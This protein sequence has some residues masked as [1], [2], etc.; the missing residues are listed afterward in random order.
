MT[1]RGRRGEGS[2]DTNAGYQEIGAIPEPFAGD[3]R[4]GG[5][6]YTE[7]RSSRFTETTPAV[8]GEG[9]I[10]RPDG[11]AQFDSVTATLFS[12][13]SE[14]MRTEF[15]N[16]ITFIPYDYDGT[17]PTA[18]WDP[19]GDQIYP[20]LYTRK[21]ALL[22]YTWTRLTS[23]YDISASSM[24]ETY[25]E[26]WHDQAGTLYSAGQT[27]AY[28]GSW[29]GG[30]N[31]QVG[32]SGDELTLGAADIVGYGVGDPV[33][34]TLQG[35]TDAL[36]FEDMGG[37]DFRI[38]N[39]QQGNAIKFYDGTG[40]VAFEYNSTE[41]FNLI[42]D[43]TTGTVTDIRFDSP[44][45]GAQYQ[46]N[47][48]TGYIW[49]GPVN[50]TYCHM[51]TDRGDFYFNKPLVSDGEEFASY[52]ANLYLRRTNGGT[53]YVLVGD[54]TVQFW[55]DNQE[56]MR[57]SNT[58]DLQIRGDQFYMGTSYGGNDYLQHNEGSHWFRFVEDATAVATFYNSTAYNQIRLHDAQAD[59]IIVWANNPYTNGTGD[60][61][62]YWD[63][64]IDGTN[65]GWGI[66]TTLSS[67]EKIKKNIREYDEDAVGAAFLRIPMRSWEY[68]PDEIRHYF[69]NKGMTL[70][71]HMP[72]DDD[73]PTRH[74][75][76]A[77]EVEPELPWLVGSPDGDE[78]K[79][80][81]DGRP[82]QVAVHA[83][84]RH[85]NNKI[86]ALEARLAALEAQLA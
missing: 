35:G 69:P 73:G 33:F 16:E 3:G 18:E 64:D 82:W 41:L 80:I 40:G 74:W 62:A 20:T 84:V 52:A 21:E 78:L 38:R 72:K 54:T 27:G 47:N 65:V 12:V 55:L 63:N 58:G 59:N 85:L 66:I 4:L 36:V 8:V 61:T 49:I 23:G 15:G 44:I 77:E 56:E 76:V 67:S 32:G 81:K 48:P 5:R 51:Y 13:E 53:D 83:T 71:G 70:D 39:D 24:R 10:L 7:L 14:Y 30:G 68:D 28:L 2:R 19:G 29:F 46:F 86:E 6:L 45:S 17:D 42:G 50:S 11:T 9:W 22:D 1:S 34:F 25:L 43:P 75:Y 26:L 37:G 57:I 79:R 31:I 60:Y